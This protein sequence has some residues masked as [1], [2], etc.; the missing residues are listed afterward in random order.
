MQWKDWLGAALF[1]AA[2]LIG[3]AAIG[4]YLK[5][6]PPISAPPHDWRY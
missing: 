5:D 1:I 2:T 6:K 4:F 3:T